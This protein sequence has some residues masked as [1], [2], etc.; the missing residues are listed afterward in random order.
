MTRVARCTLR[1]SREGLQRN[2]LSSCPLHCNVAA[3]EMQR[4]LQ[5]GGLIGPM[6]GKK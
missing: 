2:A 6:N 3:T 4:R 5:H 1:P